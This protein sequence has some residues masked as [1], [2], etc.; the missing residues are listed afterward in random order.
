[1]A[2]FP[3]LAKIF[4]RMLRFARLVIMRTGHRYAFLYNDHAF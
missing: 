3:V 1:M 2:R 4:G